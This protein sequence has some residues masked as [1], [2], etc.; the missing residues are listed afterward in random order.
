MLINFTFDKEVHF[1]PGAGADKINLLASLMI[2]WGFNYCIILDNDAKGRRIGNRLLKDFGHTNIK[3]IFV[4]HIMNYEIE[5]LFS[6]G[7]F[8]RH[9]LTEKTN[10]VP[11]KR[12]SQIIKQKGKN[13][14][15]VLLSKSFFE[16][17]ENTDISLSQVTKQNFIKLLQTINISMFPKM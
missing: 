14:D 5:D 3:I 4:S 2:G 15:N 12:N 10:E 9:V 17:A 7:D 11:Q 6:R 16:K 1:I 13:Y 8:I